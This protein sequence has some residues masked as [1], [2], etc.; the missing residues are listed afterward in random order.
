MNALLCQIDQLDIINAPRLK[1]TIY[2][3]QRQYIALR[4]NSPMRSKKGLPACGYD[5]LPIF[6]A[7]QETV[8]SF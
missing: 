7:A 4:L 8:F 1:K 3:Q 5:D 2:E 6:E